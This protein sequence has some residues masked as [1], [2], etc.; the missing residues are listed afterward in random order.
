MKASAKNLLRPPCC[1][2]ESG[3]VFPVAILYGGVLLTILIGVHVVL[4]S[5]AST[6]AQAA[7]DSGVAAVQAAPLGNPPDRS[8]CP[9]LT[10]LDAPG[11]V[12]L[13][14]FS[15]RQCQGAAATWAAMWASTR[16]VGQSQPPAVEVDEVAGVVTVVVFGS[17][18][19]PVLGQ[20][21]TVGIACG[22]L[23]LV[24][25]DVPTRADASAC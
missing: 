11:E 1:D 4:F 20:I 12:D 6:A 23:D 8:L 17:I 25:G 22:P 7:A 14:S 13:L 24:A 16:M 5:I 18:M 21:E 15:E 19:S 2:D 10:D 9:P 3:E